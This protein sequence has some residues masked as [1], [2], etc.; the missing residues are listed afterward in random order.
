M[1]ICNL[2]W[3]I[4]WNGTRASS[5]VSVCG[6]NDVLGCIGCRCCHRWSRHRSMSNGRC[7]SRS[8]SGGRWPSR[9]R[10]SSRSGE[11]IQR[12]SKNETMGWLGLCLDSWRAGVCMC[13]NQL[14]SVP[15]SAVAVQIVLHAMQCNESN[16]SFHA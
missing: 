4:A 8:M 7:T 10:R 15:L 5:S 1:C 12:P 9:R 6:A 3:I 2:D 13:T 11:G 14:C 16:A